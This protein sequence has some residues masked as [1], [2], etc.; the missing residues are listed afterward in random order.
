[1]LKVLILVGD[2]ANVPLFQ[3]ADGWRQQ[4]DVDQRVA[5]RFTSYKLRPVFVS[6]QPRA[7]PMFCAQPEALNWSGFFY[8]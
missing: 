6:H 3:T 4:A 7:V 1:M 2:S 5:E 8:W